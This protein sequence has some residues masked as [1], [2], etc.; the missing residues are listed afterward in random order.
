MTQTPNYKL[1]ATQFGELI[2]WDVSMNEIGRAAGAI[3]HFQLETFPNKSITS[4]RASYVYGWILTLA[5]QEMSNE[6]RNALL[7]KFCRQLISEDAHLALD[8]I[9]ADGGVGSSS[10]LGE[11]MSRK[12]HRAIHE[13]SRQLYRDGYYFHAVSEACK[14]Y[15]N[16]VKDKA[17]ET[18]DGH[19]LMM[20][21]WG[22]EGVLKIT[23]CKSD[24]DRNV[25]N[26]I[27]FLSAGLVQAIRNPTAH[28]TAAGWPIEKADCLDILSFISFLLNKLDSATYYKG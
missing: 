26:G 18:K 17:Q 15:N 21:V 27:K 4:E 2:K 14:A 10:E 1:I 13:H 25:Q 28:E 20:S 23:P 8:K 3:F 5:K 7:I 11:F 24:T 19:K 22:P 16:M 6:E 9:L 12:F